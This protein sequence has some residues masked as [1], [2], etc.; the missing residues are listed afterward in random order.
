MAELPHMYKKFLNVV[1]ENGIRETDEFDSKD[2]ASL[3]NRKYHLSKTDIK[4]I[5]KELGNKDIVKSLGQN[6]YRLIKE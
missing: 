3:G 6:K 4:A 1:K 5:L 2:L